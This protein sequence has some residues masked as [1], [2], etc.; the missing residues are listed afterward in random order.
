[1]GL[2]EEIKKLPKTDE[3]EG[4]VREFHPETLGQLFRDRLD[5]L[6]RDYVDGCLDWVSEAHPELLRKA[7]EAE[8]DI[9]TAW[10]DILE[11]KPASVDY[12]RAVEMWYK[13]YKTCFEAYEKRPKVKQEALFS[14]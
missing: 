8:L 5:K 9:D 1:M 14:R 6:N 3:A 11:G 2:V 12:E 4:V 7:Q 13:A 10:V